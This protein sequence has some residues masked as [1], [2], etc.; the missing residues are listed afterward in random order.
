MSAT[1]GILQRN[2]LL[3]LMH[4]RVCLLASSTLQSLKTSVGQKNPL[5]ISQIKTLLT[6]G[7]F[8]PQKQTFQKVKGAALHLGKL[9]FKRNELSKNYEQTKCDHL[10]ALPLFPLPFLAVFSPISLLAGKRLFAG[11]SQNVL[12]SNAKTLSRP[13]PWA[14]AER[15]Q[16]F[17]SSTS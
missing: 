7:F 1:K 6:L 16:T 14:R 2:I 13:L 3:Y 9:I 11:L 17:C 4:C 10:I 15:W 8:F 12:K 5:K